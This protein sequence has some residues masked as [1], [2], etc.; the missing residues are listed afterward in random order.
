[1]PL[2][3][4]SSFIHDINLLAINDKQV[5]QILNMAR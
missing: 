1:M 4:V 3:T 5:S 2:E